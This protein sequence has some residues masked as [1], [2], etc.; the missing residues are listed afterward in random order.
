MSRQTFE[1][2]ELI[3]ADTVPSYDIL[4]SGISQPPDPPDRDYSDL[5]PQNHY[6]HFQGPLGRYMGGDPQ[7]GHPLYTATQGLYAAYYSFAQQ[8]RDND[9][10]RTETTGR[11]LSSTMLQ[12]HIGRCI[13]KGYDNLLEQTDSITA[14]E[15]IGHYI[16]SQDIDRATAYNEA[17]D[18]HT[19][20]LAALDRGDEEPIPTEI[21]GIPVISGRDIALAMGEIPESTEVECEQR[22]EWTQKQISFVRKR[23]VRLRFEYMSA[24]ALAELLGRAV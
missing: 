4:M 2:L 11:G 9:F 24:T 10:R 23:L 18:Y 3:P 5:F 13:A 17:L 14:I 8:E 7:V 16:E 12:K 15:A 1:P 19:N 21:D 6:S 20:E 22:K